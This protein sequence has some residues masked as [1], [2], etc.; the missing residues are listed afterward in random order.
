MV[1]LVSGLRV[2]IS[3]LMVV[4]VSALMVVLFS[5]SMVVLVYGLFRSGWFCEVAAG[6]T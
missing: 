1:V 4:L 3:G 5:G 6:S 2:L